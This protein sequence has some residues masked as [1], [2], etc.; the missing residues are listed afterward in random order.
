MLNPGYTSIERVVENVI[1]DTGFTDEI[2]WPD[3]VEWVFIAQELIN[4]PNAYVRRVT[5]GSDGNYPP[6]EIVNYRGELPCDYHR[7]IDIREYCNKLPVRY[8]TGNFHTSNNMPMAIGVDSITITMNDNYIFTNIETGQLELEYWAFPTDENGLP[9]IPDDVFYIR[10]IE[11]YLTERIG[12]KMWIQGKI[13]KDVY[14]QF[15]Q[16][17]YWY[18]G[19]VRVKDAM[20]TLPQMESLKNQILRLSIKPTHRGNS[21]TSLGNPEEMYINNRKRPGRLLI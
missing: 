4:V 6:I 19:K 7:L 5:D 14:Q 9:M 1:R 17:W 18:A 12:R 2:S 21:Y 16:D 20:P 8:E 10:A 15:E 13:A 11:A 3:I